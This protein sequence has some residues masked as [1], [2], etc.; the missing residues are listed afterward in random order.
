MTNSRI[1]MIRLLFIIAV[2][3]CV[4]ICFVK[5]DSVRVDDTEHSV[6]LKELKGMWIV[7]TYVCKPRNGMVS[8]DVAKQSNI[9]GK[10]L[11]L[12]DTL[13]FVFDG[14]EYKINDI[15]TM[16]VDDLMAH[17]SFTLGDAMRIGCG[18][19]DGMA[20]TKEAKETIAVSIQSG[21]V[22]LT[23]FKKYNG[24]LL[25]FSREHYGTDALYSLR[26]KE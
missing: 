11:F 4:S 1:I 8:E 22:F 7:D 19:L 10:E 2:I 24:E 13:N 23:L 15:R 21:T 12:S 14:Q 9:I 20:I 18:E 25:I 17:Y 5:N 26:K 16:T 6:V 3:G